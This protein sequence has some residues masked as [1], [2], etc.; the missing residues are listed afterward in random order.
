MNIESNCAKR[1][2][3]NIYNV[4]GVK[5][6]LELRES[7]DVFQTSAIKSSNPLTTGSMLLWLIVTPTKKTK[8][9]SNSK[10]VSTL[11]GVTYFTRGKMLEMS[12][13][14]D[15]RQTVHRSKRHEIVIRVASLQTTTACIIRHDVLWLPMP[16]VVPTMLLCRRMCSVLLLALSSVGVEEC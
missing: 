10:K 15:K 12:D 13:Q 16:Q 4:A 5:Q 14:N 9:Q 8:T 1:V 6:T 11:K 7:S 2:Q 3:K